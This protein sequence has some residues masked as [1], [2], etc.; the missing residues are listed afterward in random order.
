MDAGEYKLMYEVE[1]RYWWYAGLRGM[2]GL[3]LK[4]HESHCGG[5]TL[6]VGCGTGANMELLTREGGIAMGIDFAPQAIYFCRQRGL[7]RTAVASALALPFPDGHFDRVLL[8]DVLYH[9]GIPDKAAA[10]H[11]VRRVLRPGGMA[12]LNLPA[13]QWLYSSHDVHVHTDHRFTR[14]EAVRLLAS[15]GYT[16]LDATYWNMLLF[17]LAAAGRLWRR[18]LPREQSDLDTDTSGASNALFTAVLAFERFLLR[19][20]N[21]PFGLSIM[22]TARKD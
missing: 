2:L 14:G 10:L 20:M 22:I 21:A 18:W 11:E 15:C 7:A 13:Y 9:K 12:Y 4:R 3:F 16:V 5:Q 6:D 1:A 8:M 19:R 17:P